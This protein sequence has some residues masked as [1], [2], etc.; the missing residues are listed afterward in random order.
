VEEFAWPQ[1]AIAREKQSNNWHR[2]WKIQLIK[3]G[4]LD[5]SDCPTYSDDT[6]LR[7]HGFWVPAFAGTTN[8]NENVIAAQN[9]H[10][11]EQ[12]VAAII[13]VE[14]SAALPA[15]GRAACRGRDGFRDAE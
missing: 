13:G 3:K 5:W 11:R 12:L 15:D 2:D 14:F 1:N 10:R 6:L 9:S 7:R 8:E 4:N